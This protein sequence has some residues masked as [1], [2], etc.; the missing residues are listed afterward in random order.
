VGSDPLDPARNPSVRV[1]VAG[2]A[3]LRWLAAG[4]LAADRRARVAR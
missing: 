1:A 2:G 3:V 4:L